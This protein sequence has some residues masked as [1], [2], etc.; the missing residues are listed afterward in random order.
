MVVLPHPPYLEGTMGCCRQG[1]LTAALAPFTRCGDRP[2]A[3][4]P[5][6]RCRLVVTFARLVD[7]VGALACP[8]A[9][10]AG[11]VPGGAELVGNLGP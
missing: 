8:L 11:A 4:P 9:A 6:L 2:P 10:G 3:P 7:L 5:D 1:P